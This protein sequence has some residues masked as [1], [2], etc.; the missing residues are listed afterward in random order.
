MMRRMMRTKILLTFGAIALMISAC[1]AQPAPVVGSCTLGNFSDDISAIEATLNA[2]GELVAA[3]HITA[4]M[5]LWDDDATITDAMHTPNDAADDRT[6]RGTDAIYQR[7]VYRVFPNAPAE[8][9]PKKYDIVISGDTA[10]ATGT[11]R[12]GDEVSPDGDL[13]RVRHVN[14]CWLL[15]TLE[16]NRES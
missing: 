1:A 2:E 7:Y 9:P 3:K 6:W 12:I 15:D 8:S 11:T 10:T 14:G 4:L 13:W 5:A 16:F